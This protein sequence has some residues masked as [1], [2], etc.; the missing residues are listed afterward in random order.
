M[1]AH[2]L[3]ANSDDAER[4]KTLKTGNWDCAEIVAITEGI[5]EMEA[6]RFRSLKEVD[7]ELRAKFKLPESE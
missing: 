4:R 5:E 7:A 3:P 6:G 1:L 2:K